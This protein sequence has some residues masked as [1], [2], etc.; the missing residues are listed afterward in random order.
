MLY[1][2]FIL[3]TFIPPS[4]HTHTHTL[5]DVRIGDSPGSPPAY[6][7]NSQLQNL[8][9]LEKQLAIE[10]CVKTGAES[11]IKAYSGRKGKNDRK[12]LLDAQQV[13]SDSRTKIEVLRMNIIKLKAVV[14]SS[15][16]ETE[17][18]NAKPG[19][20]GPMSQTPQTRIEMLRYRIDV[21]TRLMQ[22]ARSIIKANP[23][24]KKSMQS[25]RYLFRQLQFNILKKH[26]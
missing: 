23:T 8:E 2:T 26:S 20:M 25:V 10:Q 16:S 9:S 21:E 18:S 22:G 7:K 11:M 6:R 12:L 19:A 4:P 17:G 14:N 24:D 5:P 13:L 15:S 1:S 3:L